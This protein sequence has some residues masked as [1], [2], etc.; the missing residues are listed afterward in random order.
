MKKLLP[1]LTAICLLPALSFAEGFMPK[2]NS[3]NAQTGY[4]PFSGAEFYFEGAVQLNGTPEAFVCLDKEVVASAPLEVDNSRPDGKA[5]F[6]VEPAVNLPLGNTYRVVIPAGSLRKADAADVNGKIVSELRVP[7][8]LNEASWNLGLPEKAASIKD[9]TFYFSTETEST[10]EGSFKVYR[11]GQLVSEFPVFAGWDWD[12]GY[13]GADISASMFFEK[14]VNYT[15]TI[16]KGALRS[17]WRDDITNEELSHSFVGSYP[18]AA[19]LESLGE[20]AAAVRVSGRIVSV[21]NVGEN[22]LV[23]LYTADGRVAANIRSAGGEASL[24]L[25]AP[26]V[27]LLCVNGKAH[28]I[29]AK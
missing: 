9:I 16:D 28:K 11:E 15:V 12:L 6:S 29:V 26:G 3:I 7:A 5:I 20:A 24:T 4:S 10:G 13:A 22:A 25:P 8:C 2:D 1:I 17:V 21:A 23:S 18:G 19:G 14:D 27:Y